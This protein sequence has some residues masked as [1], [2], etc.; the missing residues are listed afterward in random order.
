[1]AGATILTPAS[2][3]LAATL[4]SYDGQ[5][6]FNLT[7][8]LWFPN[9]EQRLQHTN[10]WGGGKSVEVEVKP[11]SYLSNLKFGLMGTLEARKGNWSLIT[12]LIY[13]DFGHQDGRIK[14][15][16]GPLGAEPLAI[17][18]DIDV[19]IQSL[20]WQ[21]A[22]SYTIARGTAGTL[23][24]LGG[25]RYLGVATDTGLSFT[26]PSGILSYSI[27]NSQRLDVWDG[28]LGI[29][30]ELNLGNANR[31]FLPYYLDVGLGNYS[32]WTWQGLVG[33]GYRY[34][35]GDL[36]LAFR[37]ISYATT[38]DEVLEDMKM[39]GPALGVTFHW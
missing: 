21:G 1:M 17:N 9:I 13:N 7:P 32:N 39:H 38:G 23:D 18:R 11:D 5:W 37:T 12:D 14:Q 26:G 25:F 36:L 15:V 35:W 16:Q 24:V 10:P 34:S 33:L 4:D 28:I 30:G 27:S 29:R 6:H 20:I 8:Y 22:A 31:W 3:A 19:R 2:P